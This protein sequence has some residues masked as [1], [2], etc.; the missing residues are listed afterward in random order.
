MRCL[1]QQNSTED[2]HQNDDRHFEGGRRKKVAVTHGEDRRGRKV[3]S[4]NISREAVDGGDF[5]HPI[6]IGVQLRRSEEDDGLSEDRGTMQCAMM[7]I[8]IIKSNTFVW[9]SYRSEKLMS[10]RDWYLLLAS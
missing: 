4:V 1:R 8:V 2:L 5:G 10:L 7:N 3:E 6:R 9:Y